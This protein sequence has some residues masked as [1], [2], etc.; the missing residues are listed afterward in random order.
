M[1][2][3][4]VKQMVLQVQ[5]QVQMV[6]QVQL[7]QVHTPTATADGDTIPDYLDLD[8]D[9]D[10]IPDNIE[11]QSTTGYVAPSGSGAVQ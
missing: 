10:G 3:E 9:N 2:I 7:V 8:A 1:Q 5:L 4:M 11:G 6:F